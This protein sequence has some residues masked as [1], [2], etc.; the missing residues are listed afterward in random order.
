[1]RN[2]E[3]RPK[4]RREQLT[5]LKDRRPLP[6]RT[7]SI[8]WCRMTPIPRS[9]SSLLTTINHASVPSRV[10]LALESVPGLVQA[11]R[12]ALPQNEIC[13]WQIPPLPGQD[14]ACSEGATSIRLSNGRQG[15][16]RTLIL[17][18]LTI[19]RLAQFVKGAT[20]ARLHVSSG[21]NQRPPVDRG[22]NKPGV[23]TYFLCA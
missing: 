13:R 15:Y 8:R 1:M 4:L 23:T 7:I 3:R 10:S 6:R 17:K 12:E 21:V 22:L 19:V 2:T 18:R 16:I 9:T 11:P 14:E 20:C 5:S